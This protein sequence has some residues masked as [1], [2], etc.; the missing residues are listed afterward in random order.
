ML[1]SLTHN[2]PIF[3][4]SSLVSIELV[5]NDWPSKVTKVLYIIIGWTCRRSAMLGNSLHELEWKSLHLKLSIS[6]PSWPRLIPE[7]LALGLTSCNGNCRE[8]NLPWH[9]NYSICPVWLSLRYISHKGTWAYVGDGCSV[10]SVYPT[11][12]IIADESSSSQQPDLQ[13]CFPF[14]LWYNLLL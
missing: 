6:S 7:A 4:L 9:Q 12:L 13:F 14:T 11:Y 2:W 3:F 8:N 5:E 10:F 1:C